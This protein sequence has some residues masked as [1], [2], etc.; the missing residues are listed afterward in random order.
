MFREL[1][2]AEDMHLLLR[3]FL[4][5]VS[6]AICE[7]LLWRGAVQG[8]LQGRHRLPAQIVIVGFF[9]GLFHL[10]IY[11]FA[12]TAFLGGILACIR[13][14]SN[15]IL[16]CM[17]FHFLNN[18]TVVLLLPYLESVDSRM[19]AALAHPASLLGALAVLLASL[20]AM[21]RPRRRR[22]RGPRDPQAETRPVLAGVE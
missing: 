14:R 8:E 4:F 12:S 22:G 2:G 10:S 18:A 16:P 20:W 11:R 19:E 17:W 15:S 21:R 13:M 1:L 6:P 3:V 9:F 5:A 7:E